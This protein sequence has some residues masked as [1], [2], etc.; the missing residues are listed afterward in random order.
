MEMRPKG[1]RAR[2]H[3]RSCTGHSLVHATSSVVGS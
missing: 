3:G 2:S 1:W